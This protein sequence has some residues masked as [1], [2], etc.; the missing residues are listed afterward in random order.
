[1]RVQ[2]VVASILVLALASS[3]SL[4][5]AQNTTVPGPNC[6][7]CVVNSIK[8]ISNCGSTEFNPS[9]AQNPSQLNPAEKQ[10]FC[11]I[12]TDTTWATGCSTADTCGADFGNQ[13]ASAMA[14][15]K[16]QYCQ[17]VS[18]TGSSANSIKAAFGVSVALVA[19][20]TQAFL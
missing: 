3:S 1:M 10:C 8:S 7:T 13:I 15:N 14:S 2:T 12:A 6:S 20:F 4:V 16:Q 19:A 18:T 5:V 9:G 17:G 11:A